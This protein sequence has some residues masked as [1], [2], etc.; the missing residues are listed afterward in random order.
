MK[1]KVSLF[2]SFVLV[3]QK[4][5]NCVKI[6]AE[7]TGRQSVNDIYMTHHFSSYYVVGKHSWQEHYWLAWICSE[8]NQQRG[9]ENTD[10]VLR[11]KSGVSTNWSS[12]PADLNTELPILNQTECPQLCSVNSQARPYWSWWIYFLCKDWIKVSRFTWDI[13][14]YKEELKHFINTLTQRTGLKS[15]I[16]TLILQCVIFNSLLFKRT[17]RV[18]DWSYCWLKLLIEVLLSDNHLKI[19]LIASNQI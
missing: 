9:K 4:K 6:N 15:K 5:V 11:H 14:N 7:I 12:S 8:T 2:P 17:S 13:K 10:K 19:F 16:Y 18:V 1:I 3:C